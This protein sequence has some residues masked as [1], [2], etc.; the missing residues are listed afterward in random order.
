MQPDL[1][2]LA[3]PFASIGRLGSRSRISAP[4]AVLS[5]WTRILI[6]LSLLRW[7]GVTNSLSRIM[8]AWNGLPPR[9]GDVPSHKPRR[10][11]PPDQLRASLFSTAAS[12]LLGTGMRS[13]RSFM[14]CL[15]FPRHFA[16][17]SSNAGFGRTGL[18]S[19]RVNFNPFPVSTKPYS[20]TISPMDVVSASALYKP[21]VES[22]SN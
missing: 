1:P 22:I 13:K 11:P 7:P 21:A 16:V 4:S 15:L 3:S 2:K 8:L 19:V 20:R 10:T 5:S 6:V 14:L 18:N 17:S 12:A 9:T